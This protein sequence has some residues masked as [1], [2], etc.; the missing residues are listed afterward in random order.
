[1]PS[2]KLRGVDCRTNDQQASMAAPALAPA[3]GTAAPHNRRDA[4]PGERK[5]IT[6]PIAS[7]Y[8]GARERYHKLLDADFTGS[9]IVMPITIRKDSGTL[10]NRYPAGHSARAGPVLTPREHGPSHAPC[11][12]PLHGG[13]SRPRWRGRRQGRS[14]G[15]LRR[16][17]GRPRRGR[18]PVPWPVRSL[19]RGTA[20]ARPG[21]R[22]TH[23]GSVRA[24]RTGQLPWRYGTA[25]RPRRHGM[26]GRPWRNG[27]VGLRGQFP[28][29]HGTA[30]RLRRRRTRPRGRRGTTG[31]PGGGGTRRLRRC[32]T[33]LG[34]PGRHRPAAIPERGR[35]RRRRER[36][37]VVAVPRRH[38]TVTAPWRQGAG[39]FRRPSARAGRAGDRRAGL[40][41]G[42]RRGI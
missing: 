19:G 16:G 9:P 28:R 30:G 37:G 6:S 35:T 40:V 13:C 15:P 24:G 12:R 41:L 17:G 7:P 31:I 36:F 3:A 2:A 38:R 10:S 27:G 23:A 4:P 39:R 22:R 18:V 8:L 1:L 26:A 21:Q 20:Q 11:S 42:G 34:L 29:R 14:G 5:R 33:A 32:H 25:G